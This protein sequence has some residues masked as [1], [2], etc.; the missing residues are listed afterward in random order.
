MINENIVQINDNGQAGEYATGKIEALTNEY[1]R[2]GQRFLRLFGVFVGETVDIR[3][4]GRF[5][6]LDSA[7]PTLGLAGGG[8]Y[9]LTPA[10]VDLEFVNRPCAKCGGPEKFV[11]SVRIWGEYI[12]NGWRARVFVAIINGQAQGA[13]VSSTGKGGDTANIEGAGCRKVMGGR[14]RGGYVPRTGVGIAEIPV[15]GG[16]GLTGAERKS[17]ESVGTGVGI[18]PSDLGL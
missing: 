13:G 4:I 17:I 1:D 10:V 11:D 6:A 12:G 14:G 3:A 2:T 9:F 8:K 16:Y 7:V 18:D 5:V 15:V